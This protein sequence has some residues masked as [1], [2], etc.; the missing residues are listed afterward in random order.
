MREFR[1]QVVILVSR[2]QTAARAFL[3]HVPDDSRTPLPFV[4]DDREKERRAAEAVG[5]LNSA[6]VAL[7]ILILEKGVQYGDFL[8]VLNRS[9]SVPA[10]TTYE[11]LQK[12]QEE[13]EAAT[14]DIL[15]RERAAIEQGFLTGT[16][17][18]SW[19]RRW[20]R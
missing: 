7:R 17:R 5:E 11:A 8:E 10:Q 13:L 12:A 1:E 4:P 18:V 16:A 20:F 14:S 3:T 9:F 6:F 15:R 19:W 2:R